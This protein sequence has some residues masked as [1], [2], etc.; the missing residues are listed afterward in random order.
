[1]GKRSTFERRE[2][3]FYPTPYAAVVPLLPHLWAVKRYEEPCAGNGA[4]ISHLAKHGKICAR[5]SDIA[6]Q[7]A[8][9]KS[10]DATAQ[11]SCNGD[12]FITNP[13]RSGPFSTKLSSGFRTSHPLGC[14]LMRIDAHKTK[15]RID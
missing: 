15:R 1:M 2:R 4:L 9:I 12:C 3:D 13:P 11:L 14:F 5:A 8:N 7:S 6:P 10:G